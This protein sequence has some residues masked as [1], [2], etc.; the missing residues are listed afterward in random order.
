[1][2]KKQGAVKKTDEGSASHPAEKITRRR[3]KAEP[4]KPKMDL[5]KL[6]VSPNTSSPEFAWTDCTATQED[7]EN[8]VEAGLLRSQT[9]VQWKSCAGLQFPSENTDEVVLFTSF[10]ERG[11]GIP[12]SDFFRSVL[13][14]Y[15]IQLHHLNPN[16]IC[17]LAVFVHACEAF[18][19]IE[20]NLHL[21]RYLYRVKPQPGAGKVEV[22]GGAGIQFRQGM[23]EKWFEMPLKENCGQWKSDWFLVG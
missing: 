16:G 10:C 8:L 5:S 6:P 4:A 9:A 12:I 14:F 21:F 22:F 19:G 2:V 3:K 1:M 17:H 13:D 23:K 11:V 18:L 7:L 20:P 15:K